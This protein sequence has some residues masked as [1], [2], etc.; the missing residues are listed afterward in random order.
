[1][2]F[3][4]HHHGSADLGLLPFDPL[5]I[6]KID[7]IRNGNDAVKIE[8]NLRNAELLGLSKAKVYR[9]SGLNKDIDNNTLDLRFKTPLGILV[10]PYA[11]NGELTV[12]PIAGNGTI[13]VNLENLDI[14][15]RF[16]IRK[17][18]KDGKIFVHL[19]KLKMKYEVSK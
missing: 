5:K 2:I 10:G 4:N 19:E 9:F 6:E 3:R 18:V 12:L 13:N 1:M 17:K 14:K 7:L 15:I 8:L 11:I 16:L